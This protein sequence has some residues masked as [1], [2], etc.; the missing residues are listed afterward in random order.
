MIFCQEIFQKGHLRCLS[1]LDKGGPVGRVWNVKSRSQEALTEV[2]KPVDGSGLHFCTFKD[3]TF[4]IVPFLT[5][6][7]CHDALS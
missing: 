1:F 7:L 4:P 3:N 6:N 2:A 5:V